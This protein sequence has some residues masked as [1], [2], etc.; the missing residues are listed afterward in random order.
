M[1][2]EN[3]EKEFRVKDR[4]RILSETGEVRKEAVPPGEPARE[5]AGK[6]EPEA[7]DRIPDMTFPGF[8]IGIGTQA[9]LALG[10]FPDPQTGRAAVDLS[11]ARQLIDVLGILEEKTKGNLDKQEMDLLNHLLF[12]LRT[13]FV[14]QS[15]QK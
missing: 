2:E 13:K 11:A 5:P 12:D 15:K 1:T 7:A 6:G 9:M 8:V 4:R 14:E 3:P 10:Q